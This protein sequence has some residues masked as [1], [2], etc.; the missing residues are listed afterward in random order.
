MKSFSLIHSFLIAIIA[1]GIL[2]SARWM[3]VKPYL[4]Q[5]RSQNEV[6]FSFHPQVGQNNF[7]K[8][9][10]FAAQIKTALRSTPKPR[11][12]TSFLKRS[13]PAATVIEIKNPENI[14]YEIQVGDRLD[15]ISNRFYGT[16][17]RWKDLVKA[18]Q[19]LNPAKI[20][21]GQVIIIP[22]VKSSLPKQETVYLN[23]HAQNKRPYKVREKDVLGKIAERELGSVKHLPLIL[24]LNPGLNSNYLLPGQTIFLP[25]SI[26]K[27]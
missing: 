17:H 19:G 25:I 26:K 15:I 2:L 23:T 8:S 24:A 21:P 5:Q 4:S 20:R 22:S 1:L 3:L 16:H 10:K 7:S 12:M 14:C 6:Q 18:N 13:S 9:N 27:H 11:I